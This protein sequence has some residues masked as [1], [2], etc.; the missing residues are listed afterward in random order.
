M[1]MLLCYLHIPKV[2]PNH[3]STTSGKC[4]RLLFG[5]VHK[6]PDLS[7]VSCRKFPFIQIPGRLAGALLRQ[8]KCCSSIFR[9]WFENS[10]EVES[11]T[12][13]LKRRKGPTS[14]PLCSYSRDKCS[15][16]HLPPRARGTTKC[17]Y[18]TDFA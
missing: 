5:E 15:A 1:S 9:K 6:H 11:N 2:N 14:K 12:L 18:P 10:C 16:Q 3:L 17:L 7:S 4:T 8:R 13:A